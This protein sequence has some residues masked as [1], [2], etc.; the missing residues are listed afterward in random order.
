VVTALTPEHLRLEAY[1]RREGNWK[2]WGPYLSE[3]GWGTVREDYSKDGDAWRFFTHDQARSRAYRWN[4]D[5]LAGI[6]DRNQYLCFSL[7]L[8]NEKDSIL[9][10]RLFGLTGWEGNHGEDVKELYYYLDSTPTHS[11]MKMLYKYPQG[12]YPYEA[13]VKESYRQGVEK[14]EYE[15][16]DTGLF[17]ENRY[18]DVV[19]EYAKYGEDDLFCR[20]TAINRGPEAAPLHILP[21]LW[22]RN[23]W[24]WGYEAGPMGDV[25]GKPNLHRLDGLAA[26]Q[27]DHPAA[28]RYFLYFFGF[29][30]LLFTENET[31]R[32]R[33][34]NLPNLTPY[35]KDAFH[36]S[37]V[38]KEAGAVN[39][40][41]SGTKCAGWLHKSVQPGQEWVVWTRICRQQEHDPFAK[42][43]AT[44]ERRKQ[45]A[46]QFYAA[47]QNSSLKEEERMIQRQAFAG[48]LW[49]KQLYYYDV[50]QWLHGDPA[51]PPPPRERL[52]GRNMEWEHLTNFDIISMPD[53]WEYPWYATWDLGFHCLPMVLIDAEFAKRQLTLMT[54]EWYMHPNG[55]LQAYEWSFCDANPPVH[56]WAT[57]RVYKI[58][59]KLRG[60]A[61][62][63]F[64]EG[65]FHKLMLNFTWW[66]NRKDRA[67]RNV[68]QGGF[69]GLDNI[70]VFDRSKPLPTGGYIDQC[71]GTAWMA[72]YCIGMWR[73]AIELARENKVY[74]D[75][76]TKFFEHFLRIAKAMTDAGGVGHSLWDEKDG[77]FYD[78]LNLPNGEVIPL[79]VRSLVGLLP[80]LAVETIEPRHL[81]SCGAF[82]RRMHWFLENRPHYAGNLVASTAPGLGDRHMMAILTKE[83]L[84]SVLRYMLDESEFLSPYGIRS[85]SKFH[86]EHPFILKIDGQE[87][88][89]PYWPAESR[90]F[91]FGG[92]SNWRGPIW[93]PLN[94]LIIESLQKYH[95]YYGP[96]FKVEFPTGSGVMLD[97]NEVARELSRRLISIFQLDGE[98]RRPVYGSVEKFHKDPNFR[99]HILFYEYFNGETGQGLG[100]SHQTGWTA[101]VAKLI[102]QSGGDARLSSYL[103][104]VGLDS[105]CKIG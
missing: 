10:E 27:I 102:Q 92:N 87:Q 65:L 52:T 74:E 50:E 12:A 83:R 80:L 93:F 16:I 103:T 2:N 17:N 21:Q 22:F 62:R 40:T 19:V 9:K 94:I 78:A 44:I 89:V 8:W 1:R 49:N 105:E 88:R 11:Y 71:D 53:K 38:N 76:A 67:G 69:L 68:F 97:L 72:F 46:D 42:A 90:S 4:E 55:Q 45:E 26:V 82:E 85:L 75:T 86:D 13:L 5:G 24:S 35:V 33:L 36:R 3:R 54:R 25:P 96:E 63:P 59:A 60:Q 81:H 64:L 28:G 39:P 41:L 101:L 84:L 70:S 47:V 23:T 99:D 91:L 14:G 73:I 61:D 6:S 104:L 100:A 34:H 77:F 56:A 30:K 51:Y 79:K 29:P 57:W 18:F 43:E 48:L 20:V 98:G 37:I 32:E 7:A 66:V 95:H 58:D 15:L 31:N